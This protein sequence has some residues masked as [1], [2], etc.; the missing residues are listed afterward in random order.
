V[1]INNAD[2][3]NLSIGQIIK[4]KVVDSSQYSLFAEFLEFK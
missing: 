1:I 2:T 3:L 4:V